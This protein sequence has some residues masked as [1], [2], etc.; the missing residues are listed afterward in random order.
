VSATYYYTVFEV[1]TAESMKMAVFWDY[2][3]DD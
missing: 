2:H 3:P 1:L